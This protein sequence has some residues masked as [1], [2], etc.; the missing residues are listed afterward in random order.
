[1]AGLAGAAA[2]AATEASLRLL[3]PTLPTHRLWYDTL[4]AIRVQQMKEVGRADVVFGGHSMVHCGIRPGTVLEAASL[5][6]LTAYNAGLHRGFYPVSGPFLVDAAVPMLRPSLVVLGASIFDLNDNSEL[7]QDTRER[8]ERALLGRQDAVGA[9]ARFAALHSAAFRNKGAIRRPRRF[10]AAVRARL[11]GTEV[12]DEDVRDSRN[13][14]GDG[15]EWLGYAGRGFRTTENMRRHLVEGGLG[16]FEAGG[17]QLG[18]MGRWVR[19]IEALGPQVAMVLMP[20]S[21]ALGD[22]FPDGHRR[23]AEG[24]DA[25]RQLGLDL[26]IEVLA[27]ECELRDEDHYADLAHLNRS[28]MERFSAALG[29]ALRASVDAGRISLPSGPRR[30]GP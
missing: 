23:L 11:S 26:G 5:T 1:M 20:P 30:P 25:I 27:P 12:V 29:R 28:G 15:G 14:V 16:D 8:Y 10:V 9:V 21:L 6:H 24:R 19:R 17:V 7:V 18:E 2:M 22:A 3:E 4:P 13:N